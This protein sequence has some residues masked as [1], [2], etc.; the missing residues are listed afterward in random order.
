MMIHYTTCSSHIAGYYIIIIIILH[1]RP[2]YLYR[3]RKDERKKNKGDKESRP[4][5]DDV[6]CCTTSRI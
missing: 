1:T 4:T 3:E 5:Y 6:E 2:N